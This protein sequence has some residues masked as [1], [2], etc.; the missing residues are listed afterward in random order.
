MSYCIRYILLTVFCLFQLIL[1]AQNVY[2]VSVKVTD[3]TGNAITNV[4]V[5][6]VKLSTGAG[7]VFGLTDN[8]GL[9]HFNI[10][11]R[12]MND[13]IAVK[14]VAVSYE[15]VIKPI[16]KAV[17]RIDILM[18]V[19]PELPH[20]MPDVLV[21]SQSMIIKKGDTI[22]YN[23][24]KF[25]TKSDRYLGDIIKRLP[26]IQVDENGKIKYNGKDINNFYI[27]GDNLLDDRYNIA[28]N[29]IRT[30]DIENI[31]V[32]EN[33]QHVKMLNGIMPSDRAGINITLKNKSKLRFANSIEGAVG[34]PE[35]WDFS[36][37][38][39]S[40]K[41]KF[42]A[43]NQIKGNNIGNTYM[44]ETNIAGLPGPSGIDADRYILNKSL[45]AN[46]ND[47][48]KINTY[49]GIRVNSHYVNDKQTMQRLSDVIYFIPGRD[50][51]QYSEQSNNILHNTS[52]LVQLQL[53][54]NSPKKFINNTFALKRNDTDDLSNIKTFDITQF[55]ENN[56][57]IQA[58]SNQLTGYILFKKKHVIN[59]SSYMQYNRNPQA[60]HISPGALKSILNNN[61]PYAA[62]IQHQNLQNFVTNNSASYKQIINNWF[63]GIQVGMDYEKQ[64]LSSH[65]HLLQNNGD[66]ATIPEFSNL[67]HWQKSSAYANA[68]IMYQNKKSRF[69]LLVPLK[70]LHYNYH[71]DSI[72]Y[73]K[74]NEA[75]IF[76]NPTF[77]WEYKIGKE[78][79]VYINANT[80]LRQADIMQVYS[81][82]ILT[83][84]RNIFSYETP[85]VMGR[86]YAIS[87]GFTYKKI[88]KALF[89][90]MDMQYM[91]NDKFFIYETIVQ[92]DLTKIKAVP[93]PNKEQTIGVSLNAGKYVFPLKTTLAV[94]LSIRRSN[95][96]QVQNNIDFSINNT[97]SN[98]GVSLTPTI[99][100]WMNI[101][102]STNYISVVSD[103]T[104]DGFQKQQAGQI[105]GNT[106]LIIYPGEG[107]VIKLSSK[108]FKSFSNKQNLSSSLFMDSF[109]QYTFK[110]P[111][112]LLK[113]NC[114]NIANTLHYEV[115]NV[116]DNTVSAMRYLLQPRMA[117]LSAS[118]NL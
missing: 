63:I 106:S 40:F 23:A 82:D 32:I 97:I 71:N 115:V 20:T 50:S 98:I 42:K 96:E 60:N 117:L 24:E 103:A 81:G 66:T 99:A 10:P 59:Y 110:K 91:L 90:N 118:W 7:I 102:L 83:G 69:T 68:S 116:T 104:I 25:A 74:D 14:A 94:D 86:Y 51:V 109:I 62:S 56:K 114:N 52:Y 4:S 95:T 92:N 1:F 77:N 31:Q 28:T 57:L 12:F 88:L 37:R 36:G 33:N 72:V 18:P 76:T 87:S 84:Y 27:E 44:Q 39:I 80:A 13:S 107:W 55:G 11:D 2:P 75:Y 48:Y 53:D 65:L 100:E 73:N 46:V 3:S 15:T 38:N 89:A 34:M 67:L 70:L 111:K 29:N 64:L 35:K 78:N 41:D 19:M 113:L 112:L 9:H 30:E 5:S 58:L 26:G 101:E 54:I 79:S 17:K 47:L 43:I 16:N 108:Y 6:V 45:M 61:E 85:F 8:L 22:S 93:K 49:T 105:R 21:E